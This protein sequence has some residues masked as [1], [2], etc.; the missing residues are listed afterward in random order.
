MN[1]DQE[2]S[3]RRKNDEAKEARRMPTHYSF[4]KP[5]KKDKGT[6]PILLVRI[7]CLEVG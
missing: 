1:I 7:M 6:Q 4:S 5:D 3:I 2:I